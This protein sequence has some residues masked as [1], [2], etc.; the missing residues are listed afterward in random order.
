MSNESIIGQYVSIY[1]EGGWMVSGEVSLAKE[2]RLFLNNDDDIF[3]VSR[4][5]ISA[6]H[7]NA[8]KAPVKGGV[9][10]EKE[11]PP[12]RDGLGGT[13]ESSG[14]FLPIDMLTKEAQDEARSDDFSVFFGGDGKKSSLES[15]SGIS[16][17][18]GGEDGDSE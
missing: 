8:K 4:D 12:L 6:I 10:S 13:M 11:S 15:S 5:K 2:D 18:V 9:S 7:L 17:V 14:T 3:M 1:L 16:F